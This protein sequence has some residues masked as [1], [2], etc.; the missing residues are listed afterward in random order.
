[1]AA[2]SVHK[3]QAA[4]STQMQTLEESIGLKLIDRSERPLQLTEAGRIFLQFAEET[5]NKAETLAIFFKELAG[6]VAGQVRIGASLSVGS[7]LLPRILGKVLKQYPKLKLNVFTQN[8]EIVCD[9]VS[10]SRVD[11]GIVLSDEAPQNLQS[12]PLRA[13]PFYI[14][15]AEPLSNSG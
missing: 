5:L 3:T 4:V 9:A 6:G 15:A 1:M 13:E 7:Y 11:F 2:T 14:V 8:R 10:Q 12:T